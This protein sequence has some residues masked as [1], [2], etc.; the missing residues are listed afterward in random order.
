MANLTAEQRRDVRRDVVG[1]WC[2]QNV[3]IPGVSK[4]AVESIVEAAD[5]AIESSEGAFVNSLS[6]AAK[7]WM[8]ANQTA[9]RTLLE[10][11]TAK[12]KDVL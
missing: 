12:R 5:N 2:A 6:P 11:V 1:T 9:G 4:A 8:L 3:T 7:T 10:L